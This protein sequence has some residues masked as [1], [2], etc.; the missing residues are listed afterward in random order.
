[1]WTKIPHLW[2]DSKAVAH[3]KFHFFF[4]EYFF[5]SS[6]PFVYLVL[7]VLDLCCSIRAVSS[8][9]EQGP[10]S[11]FGS[12]ASRFGGFFCTASCTGS[13]CTSVRS[14]SVWTQ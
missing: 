7:A 14:C 2:F 13:K 4:P 12:R 1:M 8:C 6:L 5:D 3:A 11:G 10:L 9:S